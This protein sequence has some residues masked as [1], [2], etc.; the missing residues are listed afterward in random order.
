MKRELKRIFVV[1]VS[2]GMMLVN[3]TS[4]TNISANENTSIKIEIQEIKEEYQ[5]LNVEIT[6]EEI[7]EVSL[8]QGD[9]FL[10]SKD[11]ENLSFTV[12][13]NGVYTFKGLN[14]KKE[15]I[16][17]EEMEIDNFSD[18]FVQ[19]DIATLT[20]GSRIPETE[21][22]KVNNKEL[23]LMTC[24]YGVKS[25]F[26]YEIGQEYTF[27]AYD[28]E[29][30]ELAKKSYPE[31]EKKGSSVVPSVYGVSSLEDAPSLLSS[32]NNWAT[33]ANGASIY[34]S[35]G[36]TNPGNIL[37]TTGSVSADGQ[38]TDSNPYWVVID[39]GT[40]RKVGGWDLY[41]GSW[42]NFSNSF[43]IYY[44]N[45]PTSGWTTAVYNSST[46]SSYAYNNGAGYRGSCNVSARYWRVEFYAQTFPN[47]RFNMNYLK[48]FDSPST[49]NYLSSVTFNPGVSMSQ[50]FSPT[51]Y[52]YNIQIPYSTKNIYMKAIT[53][54]EGAIAYY[55]NSW[56]NSTDFKD[57]YVGT[58]TSGS[59]DV[60]VIS[61]SGSTRNYTFYYTRKSVSSDNYLN[62]LSIGTSGATISPSIS[63]SY[64]TYNVVV[65]YATSQVYLTA[66][67]NY[68]G[69]KVSIEGVNSDNSVY[70]KYI[71]GLST[72]NK[73]IYIV[74]TAESGS[75]RT[76][77]INI[78][79]KS[80][81]NTLSAL[82][83]NSG[84]ISYSFNSSTISY[85]I[86]VANNLTSIVMKPTLSDTTASV[87][88][89][90]T[91]VANNGSYTLNLSS[92]AS[93]TATVVV[94]AEDTRYTK[95]YTYTIEKTFW[96]VKYDLNGGS[97][98]VPTDNR[99]Y[100]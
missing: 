30:K 1:C 71:S 19:E 8:Y 75:T 44:S 86:P 92:S 90:G 60:S 24:E 61:E 49:N 28:K 10:A 70:S 84:N 35:Y 38:Q 39:L 40:T 78:R 59:F 53:Q 57:I 11:S 97:G 29:G 66:V 25:E 100:Q 22:I 32:S 91:T 54:D 73:T 43:R 55:S 47:N 4:I 98:S 36:L 23:P 9:T 20:I 63:T 34:S 16:E 96:K 69:S 72:S 68:G 58:N 21:V 48:L 46:V 42:P 52:G 17:T 27:I 3:L 56:F 50:S 62:E 81:T 45:S 31:K 41:H 26:S 13:E 85:K 65:P 83:L 51:T 95:T 76:Y 88:I 80:G 89:N 99:Y 15:V 93:T 6:N 33:T 7:K 94:T 77:T 64:T 79:Q 14:E 18:F 37:N 74:V 2:V 5:T 87:K 12:Y 67:A 82:S